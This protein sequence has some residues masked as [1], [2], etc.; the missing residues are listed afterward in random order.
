MLDALRVA[1]AREARRRKVPVDLDARHHARDFQ[2]EEFVYVDVAPFVLGEAGDVAEGKVSIRIV[3]RD[4]PRA[5]SI[6]VEEFRDDE[7]VGVFRLGIERVASGKF[8]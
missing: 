5:G 7:G 6:G 8:R 4:I 3:L 1:E 2:G